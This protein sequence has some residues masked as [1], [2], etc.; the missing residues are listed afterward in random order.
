MISKQGQFIFIHNFKT[1][2]TSIE[3]KLGLFETLERDVQDHR[4]LREI[5]ALT[6]R[7]Q[8][9]KKGLYALKRGKF[10][11]IGIHLS[12]AVQPELTR[13]E[14]EQFYKFSFVRNTWARMYSWYANVM[15]DEVHRQAYGIKDPNFTFRQFLLEKL[16]H[17][18][19]S[20]LYFLQDRNDKVAMDFI[21]RFENL[22]EDFNRVC[23]H[24]GIEDN[25]LPKL[26]VRKYGHYT[27]NYTPETK[28]LVS[29]L[30]K[31]EIEYF[32]F[33]FGE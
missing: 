17:N 19:F 18:T 16:N 1:G 30:Y 14:F 13:K 2:G 29:K 8:F 12:A 10:N 28:D 5:E 27:E 9:L 26:L 32:K 7:K 25:E 33:E 6:D 21:G 15:K 20:Q 22:Q 24:L 3:K 23:E 4:T 11:R 31:D